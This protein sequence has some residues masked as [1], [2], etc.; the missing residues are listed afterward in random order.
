M[1]DVVIYVE[2]WLRGKGSLIVAVKDCDRE[3]HPGSLTGIVKHSR[4]Y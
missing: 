4:C 2:S 3:P 1:I